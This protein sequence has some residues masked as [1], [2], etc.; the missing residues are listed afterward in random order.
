MSLKYR[1]MN[2]PSVYDQRDALIEAAREVLANW[3]SG[4]LAGAVNQLEEALERDNR[5]SDEADE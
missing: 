3:S 4:D 5:T 1:N 2:I